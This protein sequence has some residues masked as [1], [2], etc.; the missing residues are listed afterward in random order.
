MAFFIKQTPQKNNRIFVQIVN[1]FYDKKT[2]NAKQKVYKKLGYLDELELKFK[3]PISYYQEIVDKLNEEK[4]N[5]LNEKIPVNTEFFHLGHFPIINLLKQLNMSSIVN[6]VQTLLQG[7]ETYSFYDVYEALVCLR[8][9]TPTS[10]LQSYKNIEQVTFSNPKFSEAQMYSCIEILGKYDEVIYEGLQSQLNDHYSRNK[11][12]VFFDCTNYYFEIDKPTSFIKPGPSKEE[13]SNPIIGL[14]LLLDGDG[15]PLDYKLY[16]GNESEKPIYREIMKDM[17]EKNNIKGRV[18]RIADKGLN[19]GDNILDSYINKDGY[20]F[21]QTVKGA[22]K[23]V[24]DWI[25]YEKDYR[26]LKDNNGEVTFKIKSEIDDQ[27]EISFMFNGEK[28]KHKI[29]QKRIVFWSKD[30]AIKQ[31]Y[32]REKALEKTNKSLAYESLSKKEKYGFTGKYVE[33]IYHDREGEILEVKKE[34]YINQDKV[35]EDE[36][37]D[38]Y[39]ML[40][41]SEVDA[42]DEDIIEAYKGLWEIEESFRI[43]KSLLKT[44]PVYHSKL[45]A[46]RGH[47][48]ICISTLTLLRIIQ[49][50][51]LHN[52]LSISQ[53]VYSLRKYNCIKIEPNKYQ[54]LYID[55]TLDLIAQIYNVKLN[56][57]YKN[58]KEK[59]FLFQKKYTRLEI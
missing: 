30:F 5:S 31:A 19:C 40:V 26:Y 51:K 14:G 45:D 42:S 7:K 52:K 28:K 6:G 8:M 23:E 17:K 21:S 20:I 33:E 15:I 43:T 4:K 48:L 53:I 57:H 34:K 22:K 3:D 54:L 41:T 9:I 47:F 24:K 25:L 2:R 12:K 50:K 44:R 49:K 18:I 13:R 39:Y 59:N 37:Y 46:I 35:T 16:P 32:E 29:K 11:K 36:L 1:G 27:V 10:K 55:D 56:Q 58:E 38:G